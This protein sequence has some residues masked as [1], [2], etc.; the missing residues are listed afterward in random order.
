MLKEVLANDER[1]GRERRILAIKVE[2]AKATLAFFAGE[3]GRRFMARMAQLGIDPVSEKRPAAA[4]QGPLAG[5]G[6]VI[7][8]TLSR[9]RGEYAKMIELAGGVMQ[10]AVSSRTRY[11][12]AGANVGAAKTEKARK[13]GTEVIDEARLLELLG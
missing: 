9:P 11:L 1:K 6:C 3:Y 4:A 13:L 5:A 10:S 2:A 12:I 7:T 8:G